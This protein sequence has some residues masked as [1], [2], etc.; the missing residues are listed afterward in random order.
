MRI[1][2]DIR[3]LQEK[4]YSGVSEY[5]LNLLKALFSIDRANQYILFCNAIKK[6]DLPKFDFPNVKIIKFNY[7]NKLFNLSLKFFKFPK[8]DKLINGLDIFF[9]PNLQFIALSEKVKTVITIHDLS[10]ERYPSFFSTRQRLWHKLV[11]PRKLCRESKKIIA[12]S[13]NTK[14]DIVNLYNI[15]SRKIEVIYSGLDKKYKEIENQEE[16]ERVKNKYSLPEKFILYLG[17]IES[18]KN[19]DSIIEAFK[20]LNI[21]DLYLIIAGQGGS[22]VRNLDK[23]KFIGYVADEEKAALYNLAKI[24]VY[25]SFYEGFG[26]PPLEAMACGTPVISSFSSSLS[27][28]VGSA[29]IMIDPYNVSELSAAINQI[30]TDKDLWRNLRQRGFEQAKKFNW[31]NTAQKLLIILQN[32]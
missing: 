11:N 23:I 10:F 4:R 14:N 28:V 17:N 7:P 25:P 9:M 26:F 3:S 32:L 2:V 12:V 15:E 8:I 1:G 19:I 21:P 13:A 20:N 5:T 29:A 30:L 16:L 27:E 22:G 18:R 31:R 6:I 24:F